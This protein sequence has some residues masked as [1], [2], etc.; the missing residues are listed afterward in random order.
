MKMIGRDSYTDALFP[1]YPLGIKDADHILRL[2]QA[3]SVPLPA[4]EVARTYLEEAI[5]E[6]WGEQDWSILAR[7]AAREAGLL[8]L[9]R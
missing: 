7:I 1:A 2:A 8:E 4:A 9:S 5:A 6:G 3:L